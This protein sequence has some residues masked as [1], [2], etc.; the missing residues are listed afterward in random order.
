M[1]IYSFLN[2][3]SQLSDA[4]TQGTCPK[5]KV[6]CAD[7]SK[8]ISQG[9]VC[10][11]AKDCRDSSD[12]IDCWNNVVNVPGVRS[13][14]ARLISWFKERGKSSSTADKWGFQLPRM[15]VALHLAN[16][17]IFS[18][19]NIAGPE[20]RYELTIQLFQHLSKDRR[21]SAQEL[22][23]Y[24]HA[25]LV[26]CMDP[27]NFYGKNLVQELRKRTEA[28]A[29]YTNP[30]QILVLC[31]AGD[32]MTTRDVDRVTAAYNAQHRP[33]WTDTQALASL[34][35][36][37]LS[38]KSNLVTDERILQDML[39]ELKKHQFRNV[40][41]D[42]LKTTALVVQALLIHDSFDKDFDVRLALQSILQSVRG[43]VTMLNAYYALPVLTGN[44]LLNLSSSHCRATRKTAVLIQ[45]N[46]PNRHLWCADRSK[47]IL[48][49]WVCDGDKDCRDGS[50][51]TECGSCAYG[52]ILCD[53]IRCIDSSSI[54][55]GVK[56]CRDG[57]DEIFCRDCAYQH[58][59]C[60]D[61]KQ[62]IYYKFV[63]NGKKDCSDGSDEINCYT[64][65]S[66]QLQPL[67]ITIEDM[68]IEAEVLE[69]DLN[70]NGETISVQFSYW[71]GDKIELARTWRLKMHPNNSIYDVI[72]TVAKIDNKHKVE[73]NVV[74]GK[75]FITSVGGIEDDPER[76]TFWF[77]HLRDLNSDEE[78]ELMEQSPVDIKLKPNQEIILWY[79][80]EPWS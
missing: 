75:P 77:V 46:C 19:G 74:E 42:N 25:M 18:Y 64:A 37:C 29:N 70:V 1:P 79:K 73:Y 61:R 62:C 53:I 55:N 2:F 20:I 50:D 16:E 17:S 59:R 27:R 52:Q 71:F 69:K 58:F 33:F 44:S 76:G 32:K 13:A 34:A 12:E 51:E 26:A 31:N 56:D 23:L 48:S 80:P 6:S 24:I 9:W 65:A 43:N 8:C 7:R 67:N 3:F 78:P 35:L 60:F 54:C 38:T 22:A 68:N 30:F 45:G 72:E 11:G 10:D 21:V 36:A 28:N 5:G 39:Q 47:C 14:R 49:G 63:C 41:V 40:T 4:F 15:A 57:S 66:V